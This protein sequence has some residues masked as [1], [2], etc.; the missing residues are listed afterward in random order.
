MNGE[1]NIY[2]AAYNEA[3]QSILVGLSEDGLS[4][5]TRETYNGEGRSFG[6]H[7]EA[8]EQYLADYS[9]NNTL[10]AYTIYFVS[11]PAGGGRLTGGPG[12][13]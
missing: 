8:L 4:W 12:T 1:Y 10:A 13:F 2:R 11:G 5:T 6:F 9:K 3:P 7:K